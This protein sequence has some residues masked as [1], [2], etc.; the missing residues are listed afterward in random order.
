MTGTA[1]KKTVGSAAPASTES[2][3]IGS[4]PIA[5]ILNRPVG[6]VD[7]IVTPALLEE[8]FRHS[9]YSAY[10]IDDSHYVFISEHVI[11]EVEI[12]WPGSTGE[13]LLELVLEHGLAE[14]SGDAL[15]EVILALKL[16][17]R[18]RASP[19]FRKT[20]RDI[21]ALRAA[22]V[23]V[24]D[25]L[26]SWMRRRERE[27]LAYHK[28]P[29]LNQG[30]N[31]F[32]RPEEV[33]YTYVHDTIHRAMAR[34]GRGPAYEDFQRD[35]AEVTVDKAKWAAL[36][37]ARK[38]DSVLEESYVL[39]LERHQIPNNFRPAAEQSFLMALEK[40]CTTIASGWW[41]EWAWE[42]WDAAVAAFDRDYVKRFH[43]GVAAGVVQ[44]VVPSNV[45]VT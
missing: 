31:G 37:E 33:P 16:T 7:R 4:T 25:V 39:A 21:Q 45:M 13:E 15:P 17:H 26:R 3:T 34:P 18:F 44:R 5:H 10:P 8:M 41:R 9:W 20:M 19:H 23:T 40:V 29:N 42:H 1:A 27:T 35:G 12:A 28:H 14:C 36:P 30:R 43:Q 6:D 22:G 2:I 32:F 24:P 11:H 38:L